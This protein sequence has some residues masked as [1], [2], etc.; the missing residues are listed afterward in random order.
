VDR[1][2]KRFQAVLAQLDEG[3]GLAPGVVDE[4]SRAERQDRLAAGEAAFDFQVENKILTLHHQNLSRC[5]VNYYRM[6]I[7]LR[8]S[9]QPFV[10]E[11]TGAFGF[12]QPNRT[13]E[14]E[15]PTATGTQKLELPPEFHAAHAVVEVVAAG[16]QKSQ[17]HY[18]HALV[19]QTSENYGQ[20][21]VSHQGDGAACPKAYVKVYARMRGGA[22][23]FYKDG[24]TDLRGRFDY[25]SLSTDELDRVERFAI[26]VLHETHGAVIREAAP[27]KR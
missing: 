3:E 9:R 10:Q 15:F 7:E 12:I 20:L 24:Y 19:V 14:H 1:W 27:P 18:A 6:D 8:F 26:L 23:A 13:D 17:V 5:R 21:R 25:A 16:V 4:D 2:R 22:V 11:G